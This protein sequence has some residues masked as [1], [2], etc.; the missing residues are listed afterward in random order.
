MTTTIQIRPEHLR[1]LFAVAP[2]KDVR[3]YLNGAHIETGAFGA[4]GVATNGHC[5]IV[6]RLHSEPMPAGRLYAPACWKLPAGNSLLWTLTTTIN[7]E[8]G[9]SVC[10][11]DHMDGTL[12]YTGDLGHYPDWRRQ[13]PRSVDLIAAAFAS[14]VTDPI[15][16]AAKL[17][18]CKNGAMFAMNGPRNASLVEF[19][20]AD[21]F[22]VAM[23]MRHELNTAPPDWF[24]AV[25]LQ[26]AA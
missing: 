25:P 15:N 22:G 4:Y 16:K 7:E 5:M 11:L 8:T 23:P 20:G 18:G 14:Q 2:T 10:T 12:R 24:T 6:V 26:V 1:A 3:Y 19:P 17:L 9:D 21:A 13:V